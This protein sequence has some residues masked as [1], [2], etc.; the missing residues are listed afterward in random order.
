M[1]GETDEQEEASTAAVYEGH[2][3]ERE[4]HVDQADDDRGLE[5]V[6]HPNP[7]G[8]EDLGRVIHDG[9]D[10]AELTDGHEDDGDDQ[11]A[12]VPGL[13]EFGETSGVGGIAEA[14]LD[15][16]Q[17]QLRVGSTTDAFED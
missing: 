5:G 6:L 10:A 14:L 3:D 11:R 4:E 8:G 9:V 13:E 1:N 15:G 7:R 2:G 17:F 16:G 12:P